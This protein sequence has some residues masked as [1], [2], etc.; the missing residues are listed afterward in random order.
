MNVILTVE[1]AERLLMP[2]LKNLGDI[3][4]GDVVSLPTNIR[5]RRIVA[6]VLRETVL[7]F[8][9]ERKAS[10][11]ATRNSGAPK[12]TIEAQPVLRGAG[13][14]DL[15]K[16]SKPTAIFCSDELEEA[17]GGVR[18]NADTAV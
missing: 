4:M 11:R 16:D 14:T 15:F 3:A 17:P 18:Q 10:A 13:V 6:E 2:L 7:E 8:E 5:E 12:L 9:E 1:Q